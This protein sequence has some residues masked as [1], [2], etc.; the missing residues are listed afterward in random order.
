MNLEKLM[1]NHIQHSSKLIQLVH[2]DVKGDQRGSLISLETQRQ[3]PF[4]I[5]RVYY[6]FG[7]QSGV[8]R[9]FHA[10]KK[11]NQ[12]CIALAGSLRMVLS[13]GTETVD[14]VLNKPS[15][16]LL[17]GPNIWREMHDFSP[18]CVMVVLADSPYSESDYIRDK[19]QF[20]THVQLSNS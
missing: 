11:L 10:H 12:L 14:V 19:Q 4:Q 18:D 8:S 9:G 7:T 2:F 13:N 15:I 17:I 16:G 1:S 5:E 20:L 6:I 3:V